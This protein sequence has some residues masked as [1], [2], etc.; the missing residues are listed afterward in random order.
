MNKENFLLASSVLIR[1]VNL[2]DADF[3]C[4]LRNDP[5]LNKHIHNA[6]VTVHQQRNYLKNN[7]NEID[8]Y[9]FIVEDFNSNKLGTIKADLK[10][11]NTFSWGSW[12]LIK[13]KPLSAALQ[14]AMLIYEFA[15]FKKFLSKAIFDVRLGNIQTINFH[16]KMG[17]RILSED[18]MNLYFEFTK[19]AYEIFKNKYGRFLN[20][21]N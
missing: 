4:E 3:I 19:E 12:I 6:R 17:A 14:S 20:A 2:E 9:Y 21:K 1:P 10:E 18:D 13:N 15:F 5:N 8:S 16:K 7:F 11:N